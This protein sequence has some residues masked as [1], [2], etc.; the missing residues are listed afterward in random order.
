MA[1]SKSLD[2]SNLS[3]RMKMRSNLVS[4]AAGRLMFLC[5]VYFL[6]YLPY[7]GLAAAR[8]E[9]LEL[10]VVTIPALAMETVCCSIT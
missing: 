10:R 2:R 8:M 7:R 3:I 4:K 6:L 9:V 1:I 5:G